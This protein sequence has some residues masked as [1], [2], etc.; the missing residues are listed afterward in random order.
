ML[1]LGRDFVPFGYFNFF[2]IILFADNDKLFNYL[3]NFD[4]FN[5]KFYIYDS[6]FLIRN[7]YLC[8]IF[9]YRSFGFNG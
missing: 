5:V 2:Y 1:K 3:R 9:F 8:F 7:K 6:L 4:I